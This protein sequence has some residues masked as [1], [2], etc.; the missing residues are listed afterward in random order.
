MAKDLQ[1]AIEC[2]I[3]YYALLPKTMLV[4]PPGSSYGEAGDIEGT[5]GTEQIDVL[6]WQEPPHLVLAN[7]PTT[8]PEA[9]DGSASETEVELVKTNVRALFEQSGEKLSESLAYWLYGDRVEAK[10]MMSFLKRYGPLDGPDR[11]KVNKDGVLNFYEGAQYFGLLRRLL[12][13]AWRG[14]GHALKLIKSTLRAQTRPEFIIEGKQAEIVVDDLKSFVCLLFL[15]DLATGK[16]KLCESPDCPTPYRLQ[17]RKGD[18][19]CS[20]ECAV[21][22]NVREFRKRETSGNKS[23]RE[24]R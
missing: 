11:S 8:Q 15:R 2:T 7:L 22:V 12:R 4:V 20:H 18:R 24:K 13:G 3:R 10:V 16:I 5:L 14:D 19:F 23:R 9:A 21:L 1:Y 6:K 17:R